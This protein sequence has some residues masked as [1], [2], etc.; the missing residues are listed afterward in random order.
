M[1]MECQGIYYWWCHSFRC[2]SGDVVVVVAVLV[3]WTWIVKRIRRIFYPNSRWMV[4][5]IVA[6]CWFLTTMKDGESDLCCHR[7][8]LVRLIHNYQL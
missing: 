1:K 4:V 2:S 8:F 6:C 3:L 5:L 7:V